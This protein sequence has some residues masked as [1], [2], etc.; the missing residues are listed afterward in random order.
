MNF[1]TLKIA[2]GDLWSNSR[3]ALHNLRQRIKPAEVEYI[4]LSLSGPLPEYIPP[5][6]PWAKWLPFPLPSASSGPSLN[7][8][9]NIFDQIGDDPRPV[10]VILHL[11]GLDI[12]WATAQSLRDAMTRLREK[13][14]KIVVYSPYYDVGHYY[15]A[16]AADAI[17][18][19]R[20]AV[21]DVTGLRSELTFL[22]DSFAAWGVEAEV[23]NVSPYKTAWD[24]YA[25]ADISPEHRAMIEWMM[26]GRFNALVEAIA[27]ARK[28]EPARVRE[29][30]DCA[31]LNAEAARENGLLDAVLYEDEI[32]EYLGADRKEKPKRFKFEVK[33]PFRKKETEPE[34]PPKPR[35]SLKRWNAVWSALRRPIRWQSGQHIAIIT[36]EGVIIPGRSPQL[37]PIPNLPIPIPLPF[38]DEAIA[39]AETIAQHFRDAEKDDEI[40]AIV[41]Y[42]NSRGGSAIASDLVW[43]EM[44]RVRRKKPVVVC[45]GD[46]AASGGYFVS[47][48]AQ[49]IVAQPLTVTGSIGVVALKIVTTGLYEK[50]KANRVV[51]KRG[52]HAGL[53]ADDEPFTPE[54][55]AVAK[56]QTDAYYS[57][58]KKVVMMGRKMDEPVLEEVAGGKV[59]LGQQALDHK[60][61]DQLGDLRAA[62]EKAKELAGAP[63]DK[64]TPNVWYSGTGGNLWPP[65]F[66][67]SASSLAD[68]LSLLRTVL[69]ERVWM[70]SPFKIE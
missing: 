12:G 41:F 62:I 52:A 37:P 36:L 51:I 25:R 35:A 16:T 50:F 45:M 28:M 69:R 8:L 14:K 47:A 39:G 70:I 17:L 31:P 6:P 15:V 60:L 46:F 9:R 7:S 42:V 49:H 65:P 5:P 34:E 22:K 66:P 10:G 3:A 43:R 33:W 19:P 67:A 23:V 20:P 18:G 68:Y 24:T 2:A 64:W 44:D 21:W 13:G 58:F 57:D 56:A 61:V 59:W 26:D 53:Y 29:L 11:N 30:I 55:R 27:L 32:A 40:A 38:A 1:R 63:K 48:T 54:L 4:L